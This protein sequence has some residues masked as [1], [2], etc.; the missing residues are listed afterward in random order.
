MT[1]VHPSGMMHSTITADLAAS[2]VIHNI[3]ALLTYARSRKIPVFY[4]L[5]QNYVEGH[6][7][8]WKQLTKLNAAI[9]SLHIFAEGFGGTICEDLKPVIDNGDVVASKHWNMK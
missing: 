5:H 3:K 8:G 9:K 2:N 1:F 6:Y 7:A 4:S